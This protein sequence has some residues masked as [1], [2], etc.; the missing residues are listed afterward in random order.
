MSEP[1]VSNARSGLPQIPS[2]QATA[3]PG[4]WSTKPWWCQPWSIL[5]TGVVAVA[6]SWWLMHRWWLSGFVAS[7]VLL[8]WLLF[9]VLVPAAYRAQLDPE[10]PET[11]EQA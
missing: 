5:L 7:G 6:A 1:T 9:L 4:I 3:C 10:K 8:W 11:P 2:A